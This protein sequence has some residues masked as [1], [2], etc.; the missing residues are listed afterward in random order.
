MNRARIRWLLI[1]TVLLGARPLADAGVLIP[2]S[3]KSQPDPAILSLEE[4]Q[5]RI[6][7]DQGLMRVRMIQYYASHDHRILEGTYLFSFPPGASLS[8]FA[9]WDGVT[10]IPGVILE[11]RK[12][13]EIY[14]DLAA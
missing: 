5:I 3:V 13:A 1:W 2:S 14:R 10:R 8:D 4:M 6:E 9:I 12:A 7:V 11:K